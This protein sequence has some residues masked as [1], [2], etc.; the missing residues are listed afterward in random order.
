MKTFL[1]LLFFQLSNIELVVSVSYIWGTPSAT[2]LF[3][4]AKILTIFSFVKKVQLLGKKR[5]VQF[6]RILLIH[7]N[8]DT[9][10][11]H[12]SCSCTFSFFFFSHTIFM[13]ILRYWIFQLIS[14][15]LLFHFSTWMGIFFIEML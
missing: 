12:S 14:T 2:L 15:I 13:L 3:S 9:F 5:K 6:N 11:F 8:S 1:Q 10:L 7:V 4:Q